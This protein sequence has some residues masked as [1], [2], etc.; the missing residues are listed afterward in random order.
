MCRLH[1][2]D[3]RR[4]IE[5]SDFHC[6]LCSARKKSHRATRSEPDDLATAQQGDFESRKS[7]AAS[8]QSSAPGA[9]SDKQ[10]RA[11]RKRHRLSA[12]LECR[13]PSHASVRPRWPRAYLDQHPSIANQPRADSPARL[14]RHKSTPCPGRRRLTF[15][16]S[17]RHTLRKAEARALGC[18]SQP[19]QHYE[20]TTIE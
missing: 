11:A 17:V 14:V 8:R 3:R 2:Q 19:N 7:T 5:E 12:L 6:R 16:V 9:L 18:A 20:R 15:R 13:P 1:K 4:S 10:D